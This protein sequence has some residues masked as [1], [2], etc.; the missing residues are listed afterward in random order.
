MQANAQPVEIDT[1]FCE[2][3]TM[4]DYLAAKLLLDSRVNLLEFMKN[5]PDVTFTEESFTNALKFATYEF[6]DAH[7]E[8]LKSFKEFKKVVKDVIDNLNIF[9]IIPQ[10]N[11]ITKS[12]DYIE[13]EYINAQKPFY[14]FNVDIPDKHFPNF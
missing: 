13:K 3:E 2:I 14:E 9:K 6:E 11:I 4:G 8:E 1:I 10:Q 7:K 12:F 5:F